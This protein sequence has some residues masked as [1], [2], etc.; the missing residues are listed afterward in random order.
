MNTPKEKSIAVKEYC[1]N[2]TIPVQDCCPELLQRFYVSSGLCVWS[3][4]T[5]KRTMTNFMETPRWKTRPVDS[6]YGYYGKYFRYVE[7][8]GALEVANVCLKKKGRGKAGETV[9]WE[10]LPKSYYYLDAA[11]VFI[12]KGD[13]NVYLGDGKVEYGGRYYNDVFLRALNHSSSAVIDGEILR[14]EV[15][16]F[17]GRTYTQCSDSC[18]T[19]YLKEWYKRSFIPRKVSAE[20]KNILDMY[21]LGDAPHYIRKD[22]YGYYEPGYIYFQKLDDNYAVLRLFRY[23]GAYNIR[24]DE[25][26]EEYLKETRTEDQ[27]VY[28]SA[29]G[30]PVVF[31]NENDAWVRKGSP[32][33][34]YHGYEIINKEDIPSFKPL[35]YIK[36]IINGNIDRNTM[37]S[38]TT[39]LRHPIIESLFKSGYTEIAKM[40]LVD[41]KVAANMRNYFGVQKETKGSIYKVLGVNKYILEKVEKSIG[42]RDNSYYGRYCDVVRD[43]KRLF[44]KDNISDLSKET[45]DLVF[46]VLANESMIMDRVNNLLLGNWEYW[47]SN[48]EKRPIDK[49]RRDMFLKMCHMNAKTDIDVFHVFTDIHRTANRIDSERYGIDVNNWHNVHDLIRIHDAVVEISARLDAERQA[50]WNEAKAAEIEE[51]KK[52]FEKLQKDRVEKYEYEDDEFCIRM[53][54]KPGDLIAEGAALHHCVGGYERSHAMGETDI[55]FLRRK[56]SEDEHFYTIEIRD[57]KVI[58]IHGKNNKWLGND[59]EAIPF[60]YEWLTKLGVSFVTKLLLN[61]ATGYGASSDNLPES[62]L[63]RNRKENVA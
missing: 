46:P 43:M 9:D 13:T 14:R 5:G 12:F 23:R 56:A 50:R 25:G 37:G 27:R 2:N 31:K 30:K 26:Y 21:D 28:I 49:K 8:L 3:N 58:Q 24:N 45:V 44:D 11:R 34:E 59:P 54:K 61:K 10:Y 33:R 19:F 35:S 53:P 42:D 29:T 55:I 63:F 20:S 48:R 32:V 15:S 18:G 6:Y 16:R 62:Y 51:Q 38:I 7:E 40:L 47:R 41:G 22:K 39:V 60:V 1:V 52:T 36:D 17:I 4:K 57:N